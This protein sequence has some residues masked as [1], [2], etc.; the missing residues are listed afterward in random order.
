M[1][2]LIFLFLILPAAALHSSDWRVLLESLREQQRKIVMSLNAV[3]A[4]LLITKGAL[5]Q[6]LSD[7]GEMLTILDDLKKTLKE[8]EAALEKQKSLLSGQK[9]QLERQEKQLLESERLLPDLRK[10]LSALKKSVQIDKA[11]L[12]ITI[13]VTSVGVAGAGFYM[14]SKGDPVLGIIGLAIGVAGGVIGVCV[15]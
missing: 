14:F 9:A 13:G 12:K 4:E 7:N 3:E 8:R 11:I 10:S 5:L 6:Q 15:D 2:K 1:K